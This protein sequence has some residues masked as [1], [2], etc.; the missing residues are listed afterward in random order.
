MRLLGLYNTDHGCESISQVV[1]LWAPA[2]VAGVTTGNDPYQ[3]AMSVAQIMNLGNLLYGPLP[4]PATIP[5]LAHAMACVEI[6]GHYAPTLT[7]YDCQWRD[8]AREGASDA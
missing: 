6:G 3:Y 8:L 7:S 4:W 1:N 2:T 5:V